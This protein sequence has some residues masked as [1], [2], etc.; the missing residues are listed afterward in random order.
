MAALAHSRFSDAVWRHLQ[1][2]FTPPAVGRSKGVLSQR[3]PK[4]NGTTSPVPVDARC[5]WS[6]PVLNVTTSA[7]SRSNHPCGR[8]Q[9]VSMS[10]AEIADCLAGTNNAS[11]PGPDHLTWGWIKQLAGVIPSI[12]LAC[13]ID[14][15]LVA[16]RSALSSADSPI[17]LGKIVLVLNILRNS[18]LMELTRYSPY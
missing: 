3:F 13:P 2:V 17:I 4:G 5:E 1:I 8:P 12:L 6:L 10:A 11:A 15:G 9:R 16:A 14:S 7:T 18:E